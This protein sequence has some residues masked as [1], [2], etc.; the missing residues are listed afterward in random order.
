MYNH[1]VL[2][3]TTLND[4][5]RAVERIQQASATHRPS[6]FVIVAVPNGALGDCIIDA[7][8]LTDTCLGNWTD[9]ATGIVYTERSFIVTDSQTAYEIASAGEQISVL[10]VG[11]HGTCFVLDLV[12]WTNPQL[13]YIDAAK[14]LNVGQ[15]HEVTRSAAIESGNYTQLSN[16]SYWIAD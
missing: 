5:T 16:G 7:Y 9:P 15:W 2:L 12:D 10:V 11:S 6:S 8:A 3:H 14:G 13:V 4:D 1:P